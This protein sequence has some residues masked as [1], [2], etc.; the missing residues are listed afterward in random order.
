M[1]RREHK[2]V[3][4]PTAPWWV[5]TYGDMMSLLLAFF[6]LLAAFSTINEK[7]LSQAVVSLQGAFGVLPQ[8]G[9]GVGVTPPARPAENI[10][11]VAR[12]L[13]HRMQVLGKEDSARIEYDKKGGLRI[14]L[15]DKFLFDTASADV[16]PESYP[17]LQAVADMLSGLPGC[18]IEVRGHTDSRPL[19]S[20]AKFR[21]NYDLS[22]A[23]AD[24]I[25]R[26][27]QR[28]GRVPIE[29]FEIVACGPGQPVA[30]ND[31]EAG[32]QANRRVEILVRGAPESSTMKGLE[33]Q[34]GGGQGTDAAP[35]APPQ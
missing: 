27:L 25:A 2:K 20:H 26:H 35:A 22:F 33:T 31:T 5:I 10:E 24:G 28:Q 7:K 30:T 3:E 8:Q 12:E 16:K 13:Q 18:F 21:D 34:I 1:Y 9:A 6:V 11:R 15:P 4:M 29:Q 14:V 23:R 32:Q 19:V 17:V